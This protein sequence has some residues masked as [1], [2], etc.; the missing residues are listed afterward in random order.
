MIYKVS[1]SVA[2]LLLL[3][4]VG[5]WNLHTTVRAEHS[6]DAPEAEV[7]RVWTDADSIQKWWGPKGYTGLVIRNDLHEGGSY[8]WA[9]KSAKGK[10]SWNTGTYREVVPNRK[11]VSTM[12]FSDE[13]GRIIPGTRVSVP[14]HWPDEIVVIVDFSDSAGK[15]KVTVSEV[16]V[17]LIVYVFSKV[18]WA[19]QFDKLQS[20]L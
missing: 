15:T 1:G 9:M 14:G 2:V 6:F 4:V 11:I 20:V 18:G 5:A 16:G 12:S 7:W 10:I 17:P 8:L 3:V 19:Q 13:R